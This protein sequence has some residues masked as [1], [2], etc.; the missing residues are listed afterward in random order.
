MIQER[1]LQI[2]TN[3][4]LNAGQFAD[5]LGVQPS[6]ISHILSGRNKPSL[7][8]VT[9]LLKS[10]PDID[11]MWLVMGKGSMFKLKDMAI[12]SEKSFENN[13]NNQELSLFG[14]ENTNNEIVEPIKEEKPTLKEQPQT[15]KKSTYEEKPIEK[16]DVDFDEKEKKEEQKTVLQPFG[17]KKIEKI[18][19]FYDDNTFDELV[20]K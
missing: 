8:F 15:I 12:N 6:S 7:D 16:K 13:T 2:M 1:I 11:Y 4:G 19:V 17:N 20:K 5:K 14:E 18:I 10:F 9:K 3:Y